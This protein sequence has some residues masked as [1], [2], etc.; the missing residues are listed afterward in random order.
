MSSI[1]VLFS[2]LNNF[3]SILGIAKY[4]IIGIYN[5]ILTK[6]LHIFS[7]YYHICACLSAYLCGHLCA[8]CFFLFFSYIIETILQQNHFLKCK[9]LALK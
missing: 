9:N 6:Y 4:T 3:A 1:N 2:L 5:D 8:Y 7:I